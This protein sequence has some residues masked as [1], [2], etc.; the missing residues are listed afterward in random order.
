[1]PEGDTIFRAAR[2]LDRA[3][4]GRTVTAFTTALAKLASV[5]DNTPVIGRTVERVEARGKWCLIHLSG[6]LIL[7][8]HMLMSGSWHIYRTGAESGLPPER[9]KMPYRAMRVALTCGEMQAVLFNA[10]TVEL[11]TERALE[12]KEAVAKLGPDLLAQDFA[13]ARG[14]DAFVR[15]A[16]SYPQDEVGVALLNQRVLAGLGN[17]YKSEVAF[18]AGVHP[19][20]Q[21]GTLSRLEIERLVATAERLMRANVQDGSDGAIVTYAGPR[22]TTH[23]MEIGERLWVYGRQG[24][25]CRRCGQP[26]AMRKQ[27][28]Q[29][30]STYWCANCQPWVAAAGQSAAIP[31]GDTYLVR[32][33][34]VGC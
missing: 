24:Q 33:R 11:L 22:R 5:H 18:L 1:M 17:V 23:R 29:A 32:R 26:I 14:V 13:E 21:L 15:R 10:Q 25:A 19:F 12:R 9:W 2:A 28:T 4:A 3:L 20:R 30:R 7:L 31:A 8:S 27:G 16:H 34:K 6:D